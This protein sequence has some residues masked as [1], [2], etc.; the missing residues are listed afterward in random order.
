MGH[1]IQST[2]KGRFRESLKPEK[3]LDE[4]IDDFFADV[5]PLIKGDSETHRR[6][7]IWKELHIMSANVFNRIRR[8]VTSFYLEVLL[9]LIKRIAR[10]MGPLGIGIF[11]ISITF[12]LFAMVLING[13]NNA[14]KKTPNGV[15]GTSDGAL[16]DGTLPREKP[17][18]DILLPQGKTAEQLGGIVKVSPEGNAPVYAFADSLDNIKLIVS[19]QKVPDQIELGTKTLEQLATEFQATNI[20][21]VDGNRIYHG[22]TDK[23]V[24]SIVF[25]KNDLLVLIRADS[26]LSDDLWAGYI[27]GFR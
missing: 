14:D 2:D 8:T 17:V 19:Q 10:K 24:Q 5:K 15:L 1:K 13:A 6:I 9:P 22:K 4:S 18:F 16:T 27:V 26:V 7:Y 12:I 20:I 11:A 23:G 21:E 3:S 25:V